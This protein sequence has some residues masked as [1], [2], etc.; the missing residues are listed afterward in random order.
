[1]MKTLLLIGLVALAGLTIALP[2]EAGSVN[3]CQATAA[4]TLCV[5]VN[6]SDS[7]VG[8]TSCDTDTTVTFG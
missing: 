7:C 8:G 5:V 1:M 3:Q 2:A 4:G 6:Y